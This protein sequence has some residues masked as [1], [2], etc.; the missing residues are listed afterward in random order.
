[1]NKVIE[2]DIRKFVENFSFK[3]KLK[4]STFLITGATGLIGT[5]LIRCLSALC[6]N[7]KIFAPVRNINKAQE[8]FATYPNVIIAEGDLTSFDYSQF[9]EVDYVIHGAAPTASRF[10]V[11]RPVET[12]NSIVEGTNKLLDYAAIAKVKSFIF[13]SSLEVYGTFLEDKLITEEMRGDLSITDIRSSYP[14]SKQ[15]AE[16]LCCAY[17]KEYEVPVKI[18]RLTQTT[19]A[20]ISED[21]NR[22]IA[23]FVRRAVNGEDIVMYTDGLSARPYCYLTDA[24]EA[25]LYII[26]YGEKGEA[27]NIANP[28]SFIS[29]R[30]LAHT[31]KEI[32]NP[33]IN[34]RF[35]PNPNMGYAPTTY[36]RLSTEKLE[37][38]GWEPHF[39]LSMIINQLYSYLGLAKKNL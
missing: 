7:I 8:L 33:S 29:A 4:D 10:F 24:V 16:N 35:E 1:M 3:D 14:L 26:L 31:V 28:D 39:N 11:E 15:L 21:D 20:G 9:D 18:A 30:D 34:I 13:L 36:L 38:L 37:K 32:V 2:Q 19:G 23:Q 5:A 6:V 27:Y 22:I 17:S 25:I 12:I